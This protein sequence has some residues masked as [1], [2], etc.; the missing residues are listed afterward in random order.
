MSVTHVPG[1]AAATHTRL[2]SIQTIDATPARRCAPEV[3]GVRVAPLRV[4][5]GPRA[6]SASIAAGLR[7]SL[8]SVT[9]VPGQNCY[10]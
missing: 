5:R 6:R 10:P 3:R 2:G 9:H 7:R 8:Q 1:H 4:P